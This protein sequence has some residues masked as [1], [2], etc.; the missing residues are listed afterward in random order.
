L[1]RQATYSFFITL[2][3]AF[4]RDLSQLVLHFYDRENRGAKDIVHGCTL[5]YLSNGWPTSRSNGVV[6]DRRAST[7]RRNHTSRSGLLARNN[8][9][10]ACDSGPIGGR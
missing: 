2:K 10:L 1:R 7:T 8:F 6:A 5:A 4:Y 3:R 9:P